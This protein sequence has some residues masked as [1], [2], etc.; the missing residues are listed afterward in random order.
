MA[1]WEQ[2][3]ELAHEVVP[4]EYGSLERMARR[5]QRRAG[6]VVGTLAALALLGGGLGVASIDDPEDTIRPAGDP[7][8]SQTDGTSALPLPGAAGD[9]VIL[10]AGRYRIPLDNSL[11]F[12]VDLP[13]DT[14]AHD[15]GLFLATKEFVLK[16]E[17]AGPRYGVPR[18]PCADQVIEAVGPT[19]DDL[20]QAMV[21]LPGYRLTPPEQ[22]QLGGVDATYLE[23]SLPRG[24]D[25]SECTD[26]TL[27][28][29]GNPTTA[30]G[31]P[32][33]YVGRWW[34]LVVDGKRVVVQQNCWGCSR[35]AFDRAP[36]SPQTITFTTTP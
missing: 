31:G 26:G 33:P 15:R 16:T 8:P 25:A 18:D 20:V 19:V 10:A 29:P 4:P 14:S 23:V 30:V 34:V 32:P 2:L 5:R 7:T 11:S 6:I 27:Q 3:R 9:P 24:Y 13:D 22:V 1:D 35:A 36:R 21:R 17:L 28:L 12:E